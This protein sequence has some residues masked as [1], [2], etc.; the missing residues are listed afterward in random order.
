MPYNVFITANTAIVDRDDLFGCEKLHI[1]DNKCTCC[2]HLV[3]TMTINAVT[4]IA[5]PSQTLLE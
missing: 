1:N 3:A 4:V 5:T 2:F